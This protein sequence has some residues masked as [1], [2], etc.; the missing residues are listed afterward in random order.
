MSEQLNDGEEQAILPPDP[1]TAPEEKEKI[2]FSEEQQAIV[3]KVGHQGRENVRAERQKSA[4]LQ[5]Q[6]DEATAQIPQEVR[7]N[8][9]A[10]G[11]IDDVDYE[12]Q[13]TQRESQIR[14][15]ANF[16]TR[17]QVA[18]ENA[19]AAQIAEQ[20]KQQQNFNDSLVRF[21]SSATK[22]DIDQA[23]LR[24]MDSIV[25]SYGGLSADVGGRVL[26]DEQGILTYKYLSEH[27]EDIV[28]VN[29]MSQ[30]DAAV[31]LNDIKAKATVLYTKRTSNAPD[32]AENLSGNGVP[33]GKR[34]S[35]GVLIE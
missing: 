28:S 16:D 21:N 12:N 32:P 30:G 2:T 24:T 8:V 18:T 19:Q 10:S 26:N 17:Q 6:L 9:V 7:P 3:D 20:Q 15:Q 1:G 23:Q 27:P 5:R 31:F 34:G 4:D 29:Q 33:P 22:F 35:K 13:R 25:T 11:D 14:E